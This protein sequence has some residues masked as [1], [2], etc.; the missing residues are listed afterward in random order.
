MHA[1][2]GDGK[3]WSDSMS[4]LKKRLRS[5]G[6]SSKY[7]GV[8]SIVFFCFIH[9]AFFFEIGSKFLEFVSRHSFL[10]KDFEVALNSSINFSVHND[11][12]CVALFVES[13]IDFVWS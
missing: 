9:V 11:R 13:D 8:E 6:V 3:S 5:W 12:D 4:L 7:S 10:G 1:S 2:E